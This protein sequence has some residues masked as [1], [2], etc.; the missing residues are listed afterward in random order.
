MERTG[1][2]YSSMDPSHDW[3]VAKRLT[4]ALMW[5]AVRSN[6]T[7]DNV[8]DVGFQANALLSAGTIT[9]KV[10]PCATAG[11][12]FSAVYCPERPL[13]PNERGC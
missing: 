4:G 10:G 12:R 1:P 8:D 2:L 5:T 11:S 6:A 13:E 7:V 9:A 3:R